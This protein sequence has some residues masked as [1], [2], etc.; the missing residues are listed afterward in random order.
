MRNEAGMKTCCGGFFSH[1]K[2]LLRLVSIGR[3]LDFLSF[4]ALILDSAG[5]L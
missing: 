1:M 2:T 3:N 4:I 5:S